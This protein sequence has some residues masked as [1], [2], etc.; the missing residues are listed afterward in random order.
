MSKNHETF[1]VRF[2]PAFL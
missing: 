2:S 1:I